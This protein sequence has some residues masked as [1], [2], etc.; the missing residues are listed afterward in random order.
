MGEKSPVLIR[1]EGG[2]VYLVHLVNDTLKVKGLGV[3]NPNNLL[4]D[5][6][7][8]DN[9]EIGQKKTPKNPNEIA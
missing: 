5:L 9:V 7:I 8:G 3:F 2:K 6:K 1:E 4:S